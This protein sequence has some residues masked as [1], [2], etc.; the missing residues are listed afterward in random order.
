MLSAPADDRL[1]R[2][3]VAEDGERDAIDRVAFL[4]LVEQ[5]RRM[6]RERRGRIEGAMDLGE[7]AL[8]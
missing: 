6:I 3:V 7:K 8:F 4:D 2:A 1:D 5:R